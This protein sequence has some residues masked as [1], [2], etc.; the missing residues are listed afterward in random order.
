MDQYYRM[1]KLYAYDDYD[2]C[3]DAYDTPEQ[4]YCVARSVVKPDNGSELYRFIQDFSADTYR[5]FRHDHLDRGL[6]VE[7]CRRLVAGL[8]NSTLQ[9]LYVEKFNIDFPVSSAV[10]QRYINYNNFCFQFS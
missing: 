4:V 9:Q 1:P 5:H 8:D 6:C 10:K 3:F 2:E 7:R